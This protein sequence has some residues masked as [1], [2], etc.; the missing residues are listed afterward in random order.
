MQEASEPVPSSAGRVSRSFS[1]TER[2]TYD[3]YV[4]EGRLSF[5][6]QAPESFFE[7]IPVEQLN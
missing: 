7:L 1:F 2:W 4:R 3:E 5:G 6:G